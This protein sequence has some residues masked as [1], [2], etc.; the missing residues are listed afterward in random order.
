MMIEAR[1]RMKGLHSVAHFFSCLLGCGGQAR[2]VFCAK[3]EAEGSSGVNRAQ[4]IQ[5]RM[6]LADKGDPV[7][8]GVALEATLLATLGVVE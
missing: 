6:F 5:I 7:A 3:E 2:R 4:R 1:V 8:V